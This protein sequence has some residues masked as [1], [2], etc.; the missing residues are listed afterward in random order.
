[1]ATGEIG[2][3][4]ANRI[5]QTGVVLFIS[6]IA[7]VAM[8]LA[9][10]ALIRSIDTGTIVAG[11]LSFKQSAVLSSD[12]GVELARNWL[13]ANKPALSGDVPAEGYYASRQATLD[14]TG[15]ATGA[16]TDDV[17]WDGT[18]ASAL[19][20]PKNVMFG[21]SNKDSAGNTVSYV[22]HRLCEIVGSINAPSQSCATS[23]TTDS[24]STK[25][26][27][28]YD[29]YGLTEKQTIYYRVTIRVGGPRNTQTFIQT[30]LLF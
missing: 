3:R 25:D 9:A 26:A 5:R 4:A 24:G 19:I 29:Q 28:R 20:T 12:Y 8:S 10:I 18:N 22:I 14:L 13:L 11:N 7:L 1:M 17:N 27:P 6:L 21:A 15:T 23:T 30:L 2:V 16:K